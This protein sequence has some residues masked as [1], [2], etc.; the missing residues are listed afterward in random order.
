MKRH[1]FFLEHISKHTQAIEDREL[2]HQISRVLRLGTGE[3]IVLCKGDGKEYVFRLEYIGHHE[4][5][6]SIVAI[7]ENRNEP[8]VDVTLYC[9]LLKRE[10]FELVVQKATEVGVATIVPVITERTVKTSSNTQRL[11][12][13]LREAAEQSG[14]AHI[15]KLCDALRL[16]DALKRVGIHDGALFFD[17]SGEA[18]QER[19]ARSVKTNICLFIGPEG[20]WSESEL[21]LARGSGCKIA[22]LGSLTLRAETAAIVASYLVCRG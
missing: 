5:R 3:E 11:E 15:P 17:A 10:N 4:I 6:G 20:G 1:R 16:P 14:R 7:Q 18:Y 12:K 2:C 13:I 9:A 19:I 21:Q 8:S 22:S